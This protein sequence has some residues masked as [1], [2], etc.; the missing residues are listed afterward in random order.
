MG[1]CCSRDNG[2]WSP[3]ESVG[4]KAA[5]SPGVSPRDVEPQRTPMVIVSKTGLLVH[6]NQDTDDEGLGLTSQIT[7]SRTASNSVNSSSLSH[8][9]SSFDGTPAENLPIKI[10]QFCS[11]VEQEQRAVA[12]VE[13][14]RLFQLKQD[15][16]AIPGSTV[17]A[18]FDEHVVDIVSPQRF[19]DYCVKKLDL[20]G[21]TEGGVGSLIR[22]GDAVSSFQN[23]FAKAFDFLNNPSEHFQKFTEVQLESPLIDKTRST[24]LL[25]DDSYFVDMCTNSA[26]ALFLTKCEEIDLL[27]KNEINFPE[28]IVQLS[29][30]GRLFEMDFMSLELQANSGTSIPG[31][32]ALFERAA[33]SE[34][35]TPKLIF[36]RTSAK[37]QPVSASPEADLRLWKTAKKIFCEILHFAELVIFRLGEIQLFLEPFVLSL[38]R[39][40][41]EYH[42]VYQILIQNLSLVLFSGQIWRC[43]W[44][45][46]SS[47]LSTVTGISKNSISKT[48]SSSLSHLSK[49]FDSLPRRLQANK[50][51]SLNT[52]FLKGLRNLWEIIH[53][54]ISE[55]V[56]GYYA[57]SH[58]LSEDSEIQDWITECRDHFKL[59]FLKEWKRFADT[60]EMLVELI[61]SLIFSASVYPSCLNPLAPMLFSFYYFQNPS[62]IDSVLQNKESKDQEEGVEVLE[63]DQQI[64]LKSA[65]ILDSILF[66]NSQVSLCL[67]LKYHD[68]R[69]RKCARKLMTRLEEFEKE[70]QDLIGQADHQPYAPSKYRTGL[71]PGNLR[72]HFAL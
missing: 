32:L 15:S 55:Y 59:D 58:D 10:P 62:K 69:G 40:V 6:M 27:K 4:G 26:M 43:A 28:N 19:V 53:D 38:K 56:K 72:Q 68:H 16:T 71:L 41:S 11:A 52:P 50:T 35:L 33:D 65:L 36:L 12:L 3:S 49:Q 25:E 37:D 48:I 22:S 31:V 34:A 2:I 18:N 64:A 21:R 70:M 14:K 17:W 24:K 57:Q 67:E 20:G 39:N 29:N 44:L 13:A 8:T 63:A 54:W 30:Q 60:R 45:G 47:V 9:I 46:E 23:F 1:G 66:D 61:V 51:F 7:G 42:P 5:G